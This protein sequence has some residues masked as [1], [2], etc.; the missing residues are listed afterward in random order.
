MVKEKIVNGQKCYFCEECYF[1]YYDIKKARECEEWCKKH[2]SCN[3]E[4][5]KYAIK[6]K[7]VFYPNLKKIILTVVLFAGSIM[8]ILQL[9]PVFESQTIGAKIVNLFLSPANFLFED[10]FG[11]NSIKFFDYL[12]WG[13]Q[14]LYMYIIASLIL[15]LVGGGLK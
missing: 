8:L 12:T 15:Y 11:V 1:V 7:N 10:L 13:L 2:K 9:I 14:F 5:V 3:L 6:K 4:I